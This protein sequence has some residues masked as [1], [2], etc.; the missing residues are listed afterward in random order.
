MFSLAGGQDTLVVQSR[1][2][3][4]SPWQRRLGSDANVFHTLAQ[5][6]KGISLRSQPAGQKKAMEN[7]PP[8]IVPT[9][10]SFARATLVPVSSYRS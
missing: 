6:L 1:L 10:N 8:T 3:F 2:Y 4:G 5:Q 9:A 7:F